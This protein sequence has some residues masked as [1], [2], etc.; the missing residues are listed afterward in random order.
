MTSKRLALPLLAAPL[1]V[2][3]LVSPAAAAAPEGG[4]T[5]IQPV[6]EPPIPAESYDP[7][8][9]ILYVPLEEVTVNPPPCKDGT[10][11]ANSAKNCTNVVS[12]ETTVP[13]WGDAQAQMDLI[14][15]L[16]NALAP[17]N[18]R[19]TTERPD[20]YVP[21]HMLLMSDMDVP[22]S[23][24]DV[25]A[26]AAIGCD[27]LPR[28]RTA[29]VVGSTMNC[30]G[31]DPLAAAL[32][33]FGRLSGLEP[34][35]DAMDPMKVPQ[36]PMAPETMYD[37]N[38]NALA[39]PDMLQCISTIHKLYCN[40]MDGVQ[41]SHQE[42][43][44]VYGARPAEPDTTA[45][46]IDSIFPEDGATFTTSDAWTVSA[47]ASDDSG[48]LVAR[49][50]WVEGI[51]DEIA[52]SWFCKA[53]NRACPQEFENGH[54]ATGE[55]W[56]FFAANGMPPGTYKFRFTVQDMA[57]NTASQEITVTVEG[58]SGS[59]SG[60]ATTGGPTSAGSSTSGGGDTT[61]GIESGGNMT[62]GDDSGGCS[63]STSA[64]PSD[65]AFGFGALLLA[66]LVR[67]RRR[68]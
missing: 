10:T 65:A 36:D 14:T 33:A 32:Y 21:Y 22:E 24:A 54:G 28:N 18:V 11:Q 51:P 15:G 43:L 23:E 7:R 1:A 25:C 26:F 30:A 16:E 49:W 12:E 35:A 52:D 5:W 3:A 56:D 39:S 44:G 31:R 8:P 27:G 9:G 55:P 29:L 63:C 61:G 68:A 4:P 50:D 67:R 41:N 20:D 58:S 64:R 13:P 38:C 60:G 48:Y 37:D 42:L 53:T 45:P 59:T 34:L 2:A 19:I 17:Y 57:G 46:T 40:D 66:G 6:P 62:D 47:T